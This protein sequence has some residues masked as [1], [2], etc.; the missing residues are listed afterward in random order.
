MNIKLPPEAAQ[1]LAA[2]RQKGFP[3]YA[4][5]GGVRDSLL[6]RRPGDW[7]IATAALPQQ[8]HAALAPIPVVD[9]GL[10]HGTVTALLGGRRLRSPP[11]VWTAPT[12]TTAGRTASSLPA[13]CG[14]IWPGG[15]LP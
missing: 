12:A 8:V 3:A 4:V 10:R 11:S 9:T 5:G 13:A 6:G 14:R 1:V 7:D 15:I 2:L